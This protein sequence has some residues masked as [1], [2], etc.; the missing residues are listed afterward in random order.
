MNNPTASRITL[1]AHPC[2]SGIAALAG[3]LA[4]ATPIANASISLYAEYH[5][6]EAGSLGANNLPLDSSGNGKSLITAIS[7]NTAT[8]G[9]S[10]VSAPGSTTY[11]DTSGA[12]NEG[13]YA[14]GLYSTA[15]VLATDN[16]AFGVYASAASIASA[17]Q[18]DVFTVGGNNGAFKL[19]LDVNGWAASSHNVAWIGPSGGTSG[20]FTANTW[21]HLALIRSAGVATFYING[22][23]QAGTYSG[24]PVIDTPHMSV[25]PGGSVYFDGRLDEARVVTFAAGESTA[26]ILSSLQYGVLATP[27]LSLASGTYPGPQSVAIS[28]A[29]TGTTIYYTTDGSTPTT[30]SSVYSTPITLTGPATT[31]IRTIAAKSGF[32]TTSVVSSTY[33]MIAGST[34]TWINS[35]GGSW[36]TLTNWQSS[37]LGTGPG[38]T[39]DFGT[40]NLTADATVTLDGARTLG[41][42]VFA[43][44]TP[45]FN[46]IVNPGSGG[47]LTLAVTSGSPTITVTNQNATIAMPLA[48]TQGLTKTGNGTLILTATNT[49]TGGTTVNAGGTLQVG[50][51]TT[52]GT[53]GSGN[54]VTNGLLDLKFGTATTV[55]LP[56]G[57]AITGS[58][59]LSALAN[60]V[61]MNGN[62]TLGGSITLLE[63]GNANYVY[64]GLELATTSTLTAA[65]ITLYGN[66]GKQASNGN[67]LTLDTSAVNG[68][69]SMQISTG[70]GNVWYTINSV[71]ANAGT[72]TITIPGVGPGGPWAFSGAIPSWL[73]PTTLRG[74]VQVTGNV[75]AGAPVAIET[76]GPSLAS[77]SF[78][79]AMTLTKTGTATLTLAGTNTYTGT[80]TVNAGTLLVTGST[81]AASGVTVNNTAILGGTGTIGGAVALT[82]GTTLSPGVSAIGTLTVNN[83]LTLNAGSTVVMEISKNGGIATSDLITG[84]TGSLS[85]A[86]TLTIDN[87]TSDSTPLAIGDKFHLFTKTSGGYAGAFTTINLPALPPDT[88]WDTSGLTTDGSILVQNALVAAAP[89]ISL[90]SGTYVGTQSITMTAE[91]GATI[92]FT[93]D[94]SPPTGASAVYSGAITIPVNTITSV[95]ALATRPDFA[96]SPETSATYTVWSTPTWLTPADGSW[97]TGTNWSNAFVPN[98]ADIPVDFSTLDLTADATVSLGAASIT[99]GTMQFGDTTPSHNWIIGSDGTLT[100]ATSTGTP[101]IEVVNRTATIH[102]PVGGTQGLVKTGPGTL[103]LTAANTYSGTTAIN[104]GTLIIGNSYTSNNYQIASGAVLEMNVASGSADLA[105]AAFTGAGTLRKTGSGQLWWYAGATEVSLAAGSLVDVQGGIVVAGD[106][107]NDNWTA[108]LSDLNVAAGAVFNGRDAEVHVNSLTG[109]GQIQGGYTS[110][111]NAKIIC[112]VANGSGTFSG[113]ITNANAPCPFTKTGTGT[114]K[115]TGTCTHT[116]PTKV[117]AG[118]LIVNGSLATGT[119]VTVTG[120]TL[121]GT[122]TL[123][124]SVAINAGT[125]IAPGDGGIGTL[126][127]GATTL[128]GT[129]AC[130]ISDAAADALAVTGNLNLTGSTL[131]VTGTTTAS[132]LVIATYTGTLSGTFTA[133]PALPTGYILDYSTTGEIRLVKTGYGTWAA[134]NGVTG[135]EY[136]DSD[137][138]GIPNLVEY[139][140]NLNPAASDGSA[141]TLAGNVITFTKR[142]DAIANAD[143]SYIVETSATLEAGSWTPVVTQNPGG[144]G[145]ADPTISYSLPTGPGQM[146]ARLVVTKVP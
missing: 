32:V 35:A 49:Y 13:W 121:G 116:G 146:F 107:G 134:A 68:P 64:E 84:L 70:L 81:A 72:G 110:F 76:T 27:T 77:G 129:Y 46:W 52:A 96:D 99:V 4:I 51:G 108:N 28:C 9:T 141:G 138:D 80:T 22:V 45:D 65:A 55:S 3:L 23:A 118:T 31:T 37:A 126:H 10:E 120:G 75:P 44:T 53:L 8:T 105:G 63:N 127:T 7:G 94:G 21:V 78:S 36:P 17:N 73:A 86:G 98:G 12:G 119:A 114:Q 91:T 117:E 85:Y 61:R 143:V 66:L 5:L 40:L 74:A 113:S 42:L 43:D 79:G 128:A 18:G 30:S 47:P 33:V 6:G 103:A 131:T 11:L 48:G 60:I 136:G 102:A 132:S 144:T 20:S 89:A 83:S 111:P 24:A 39:A 38:I 101:T 109:G 122:G 125:T 57:A 58:G 87:I 95:R 90:I 1:R 16:F 54:I 133:S 100:L 97:L 71:T 123:G 62:I 82:S 92:H 142:A 124:G 29:T 88:K 14:S 140:L 67:D 112:G 2:F 41:N 139:A 15:P 115:L 19:S 50:N 93:T 69:I 26:N 106:D 59:S 104:Q 135:G 145:Y 137:H 25:S 130:D 56:T 34:A